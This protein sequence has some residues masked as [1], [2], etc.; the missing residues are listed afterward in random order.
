MTRGLSGIATI[1]AIMCWAPVANGQE[2]TERYIPVGQSPGI[3]GVYSYIGEIQTVDLEN[4]TVTVQ[5]PEGARTIRV[6]DE[7]RIWLDRSQQRL[8]NLVGGME[9]LQPGRRV[10]IKYV[11]YETKDAAYWIKVEMPG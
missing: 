6:T 3:S 5:G 8:T 11:D 10:E 9:D 7:T 4:R 1:I 2:M